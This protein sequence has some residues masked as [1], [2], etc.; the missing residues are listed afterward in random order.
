M[1][2]LISIIIPIYNV[3]DYL[4]KCIDSLICQTYK[5]IEI[6]LIDDGS[7]D[8]SGNICDEY[9]QKD[10]RIVVIHQ[11]NGGVSSARNIALDI[12]KGEYIMFV[13]GDDWV[14]P[15]F[16]EEAIRMIHSNGVDCV[17]FGYYEYT[18][19]V[20]SIKKTSRP[21]HISSEEAIKSIINLDDVIYNM[22]WNKISHRKLFDNVRFPKGRLYEDQAV[23]YKIFDKAK[24]I[25]VSDKPLYNYYRRLG[26]T[27]WSPVS[28]RIVND[29]FDIWNERFQFIKHNYPS[30][31]ADQLLQLAIHSINSLCIMDWS[32][33]HDIEKKLID[34]L[35]V[36]K[37]EI[38]RL[39]MPLKIKIKLLG[40]Y[41]FKPLFKFYCNSVK[42]RQ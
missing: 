36:N 20:K 40:F 23:F 37:H 8:N 7:P 1:N 2:E 5:N 28:H 17:S 42:Y 15:N 18:N 41:Y 6:I 24:T 31:I 14:E 38:L 21:R 35:L 34:F 25:Y 33:N 30:I 9:A 11:S 26:S 13:D 4:T 39:K 10:G 3:E 12:C 27:T 22:P 19:G 32:S 16:C 29:K